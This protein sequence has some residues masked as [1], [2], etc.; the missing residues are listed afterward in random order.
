MFTTGQNDKMNIFNSSLES[1]PR[2]QYEKLPRIDMELTD[3]LMKNYPQ[4]V[5]NL[6]EM[7]VLMKK[8]DTAIGWN[9]KTDMIVVRAGQATVCVIDIPQVTDLNNSNILI[10]DLEKF[11]EKMHNLR[12]GNRVKLLNNVVGTITIVGLSMMLY[13]IG[14]VVGWINTKRD[15]NN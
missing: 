14:Y 6:K 2:A 15:N 9:T 13:S 7:F 1:T 5:N 4:Y 11:A 3:E 10:F 12:I 8:F